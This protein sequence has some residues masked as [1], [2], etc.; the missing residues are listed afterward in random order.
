MA[1]AGRGACA[2]ARASGPLAASLDL[3]RKISTPLLIDM[4]IV[5][6]QVDKTG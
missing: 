3:V 1:A 5:I 4:L 6:R 2:S